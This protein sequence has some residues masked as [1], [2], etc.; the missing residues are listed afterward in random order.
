MLWQQ[1]QKSALNENKTLPFTSGN[2]IQLLGKTSRQFLKKNETR[3]SQ[4]ATW[5]VTFNLKT[6]LR[7]KTY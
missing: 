7:F 2:Q 4:T 1:I 3:E 5:M 6:A